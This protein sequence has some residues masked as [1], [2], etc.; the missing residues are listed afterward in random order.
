MTYLDCS[1]LEIH[2]AEG[3][4]VVIT[5]VTACMPARNDIPD[6]R[7]SSGSFDHEIVELAFSDSLGH[8][9]GQEVIH[10]VIY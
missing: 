3:R 10:E 4:G 8:L 2:G 9:L 6:C 7:S 1:P 5:F